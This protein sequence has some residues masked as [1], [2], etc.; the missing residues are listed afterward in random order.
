MATINKFEDLE[1][2]LLARVQTNDVDLLVEITPLGKN[3]GRK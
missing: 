3:Y 1:I 2:G